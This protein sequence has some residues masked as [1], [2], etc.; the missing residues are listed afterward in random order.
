MAVS[1][2]NKLRHSRSSSTKIQ[3]VTRLLIG[4]VILLP[5]VCSRRCL[6]AVHCLN[7][8]LSGI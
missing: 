4:A 6:R 8:Q 3:G 7:T 2:D 5:G 1:T